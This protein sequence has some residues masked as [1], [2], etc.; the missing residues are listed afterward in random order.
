MS[1]V[2]AAEL[3]TAFAAVMRRRRIPWY[4]FGA[5]AVVSY[6]PPRMTGDVD[7][8]I[9]VDRAKIPALL[10]DLESVRFKVAVPGFEMHVLETRVLPLVHEPTGMPL[11]LVFAGP[12]IEDEF[13]ARKRSVDVGGVRVPMI[14]VEDLIV[15]KILA[16]RSKDLDDVRGILGERSAT[17]DLVQIRNVLRML[18]RA[19]DQSDLAPVFERLLAEATAE[20][21]A[22][23]K[24]TTR[25]TRKPRR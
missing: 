7:I 5:Q 23:R 24:A 16:S 14:G 20:Q 13:F 4:V 25:P 22:R 6:G 10:R 15:T 2:A 12:G 19:L 3:L 9:K 1:R 18:E 21:P 8:T 17:L 11:D